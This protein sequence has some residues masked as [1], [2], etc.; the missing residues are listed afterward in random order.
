MLR[1]GHMTHVSQEFMSNGKCTTLVEFKHAGNTESSHNE[2]ILSLYA[3]VSNLD[4]DATNCQRDPNLNEDANKLCMC[5][6]KYSCSSHQRKE[7]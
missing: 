3:F 6:Q 2:I 5:V 1:S 7:L 4:I